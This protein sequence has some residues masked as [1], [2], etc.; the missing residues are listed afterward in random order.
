[1]PWRNQIKDEVP[2]PSPAKVAA[3]ALAAD[4]RRRAQVREQE[5]EKRACKQ[6][7]ARFAARLKRERETKEREAARRK[8]SAAAQ[9]KTK[10]QAEAAA[11]AERLK[12]AEEDVDLRA[13]MQKRLE[14]EEAERR[15]GLN[16]EE[17]AKRMRDRW[18]QARSQ[19]WEA[20]DPFAKW[21]GTTVEGDDGL[22]VEDDDADEEELEDGNDLTDEERQLAAARRAKARERDIAARRVLAHS[23]KTLMDAL[24]LEQAASDA[25]VS[26]AMRKILRL[27]HPDYSI[28]MAEK[29]TKR[30]RRIEA[31]FKRLSSLRAEAE[32]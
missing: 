20:T 7:K 26:S 13:R 3:D 2:G 6:A 23:S 9:A 18:Q 12:R 22:A 32:D 8:A 15:G 21:R 16:A 10:R 28:N 24:G 29:G 1:M 14:V 30:H 19:A 27:L 11:E 25:E 31:A 5:N 17:A 4:H